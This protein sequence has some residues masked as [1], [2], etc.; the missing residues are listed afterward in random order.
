LACDLLL[1]SNDVQHIQGVALAEGKVRSEILP[2]DL[3]VVGHSKIEPWGIVNRDKI[4]A[5][6]R[7]VRAKEPIALDLFIL[8]WI[9]HSRYLLKKAR[10]TAPVRMAVAM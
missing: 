10:R 1:I 5:F 2:R 7:A 6:N 3:A 4:E 8:H 9:P